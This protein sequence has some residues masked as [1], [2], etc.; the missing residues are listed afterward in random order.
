MGGY[1]GACNLF[2]AMRHNYILIFCCLLLLFSCRENKLDGKIQKIRCQYITWACDC[3]NWARLE[4]LEKYEN[5]G[6]DT[7]ADHCI[8]ME[9]A[10]SLLILPDS[11]EANSTVV[12]FTGQF[13][14]RKGFPK[15]YS[16][17]GMPDKARIFRYTK[18]QVVRRPTP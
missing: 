13:Y 15:G 16:S 9:P 14:R 10:D 7:L 1:C 4:D 18:Y 12:E 3:A 17:I 8:F 11:L 6:G 5:A 2:G